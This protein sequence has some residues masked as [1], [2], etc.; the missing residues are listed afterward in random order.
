MAAQIFSP[1]ASRRGTRYQDSPDRATMRVSFEEA[2]QYYEG[3]LHPR[4]ESAQPSRQRTQ[5]DQ[6]KADGE[7]RKKA[8]KDL[9]Q[10]WMD[11]LQLISV[12]TTF[13]AS[14][15]SQLVGNTIPSNGSGPASRTLQ[16]ANS[17]LMGALV[18]HSFAAIL[19]FLGAFILV[20]YKVK[21]AKKEEIKAE[22]GQPTTVTSSPV[23]LEKAAQSASQPQMPPSNHT[24]TPGAPSEMPDIFCRDPRLVQVGPFSRQPPIKIL[25]RVHSLCLWTSA[26]GFVLAL[27]GILC[28][29]WS[30]MPRSVSVVSSA[31]LAVCVLGSA[32]TL[33]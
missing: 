25:E 18:M 20:R 31:C 17:G 8:V 15:E 2:P 22:G 10:S 23:D 16:A 21:E 29:S 33:S 28:F 9:V 7:A 3:E 32:I 6:D 14:V 19:S 13:F 26:V 5:E 11:R 12:I 1:T 27:M 24:Q 30:V 4:R